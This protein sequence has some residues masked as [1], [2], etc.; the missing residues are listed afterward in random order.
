[1]LAAWQGI[2]RNFRNEQ[3]WRCWGPGRDKGWLEQALSCIKTWHLDPW[4]R[5]DE[6]AR[7]SAIHYRGSLEISHS[8]CNL[9]LIFYLFFK[10]PGSCAARRGG[11][12]GGGKCLLWES[13]WPPP[14]R[15]RL[16]EI[17]STWLLSAGHSCLA[18]TRLPTA[19]WSG[20]KLEKKKKK[21]EKKKKHFI[22]SAA[23]QR[24]MC[25]V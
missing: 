20:G 5:T 15:E 3:T 24:A 11:G 18:L 22:S 13:P 23:K 8:C 14:A 17:N 4:R 16:Q 10:F 9:L 2:K 19:C 12:W 21:A 7:L 25:S 6:Q 1:M